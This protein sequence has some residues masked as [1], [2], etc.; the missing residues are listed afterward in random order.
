MTAESTECWAS[1][2]PLPS[3]CSSINFPHLSQESWPP[4]ENQTSRLNHSLLFWAL[5]RN[6]FGHVWTFPREIE[7][8]GFPMIVRALKPQTSHFLCAYFNPCLRHGR[9]ELFFCRAG[10]HPLSSL[11][12]ESQGTWFYSGSHADEAV[13]V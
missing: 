12:R 3:L 5:P 2:C 1:S 13:E 10:G 4:W 8:V 7:K 6:I 9:R 11:K